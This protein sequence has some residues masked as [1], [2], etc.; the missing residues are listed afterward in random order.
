MQGNRKERPGWGGVGW[1]NSFR[2]DLRDKEL[3]AGRG[4]GTWPTAWG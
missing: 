1:S 3:L 2:V 4:G